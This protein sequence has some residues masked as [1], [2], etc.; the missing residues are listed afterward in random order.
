MEMEMEI[1]LFLFLAALPNFNVKLH[2][3]LNILICL[4]NIV[5]MFQ[6]ILYR[7]YMV[8]GLW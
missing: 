4:A 1:V 5:K 2:F 3:S 7:N 8:V 6:W